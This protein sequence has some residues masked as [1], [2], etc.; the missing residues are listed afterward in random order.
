[1]FCLGSLQSFASGL[2]VVS[3]QMNIDAAPQASL[4]Y[5]RRH[6]LVFSFAAEDRTDVSLDEVSPAMVAAVL[7]AEDRSFFRH[8]GMNFIAIARAFYV[9]LRRQGIRQGGS[10]ITQQLVRQVALTPD[11]TFDRKV[12]EALLAFRL[13]RR[14]RKRQILAAYLNRIYLG[15]GHYGVE[16]AARGY[17]GKTAA[18]LN[19]AEAALLAGIIRCPGTC[20]P[21][22]APDAARMRRNTV[23]AAMRASGAV[24]AA[25]YKSA[26]A[27]P[28]VL[29]QEGDRR[30]PGSRGASGMYFI[31][32]VRRQVMSRFGQDDVLRGGLRIYTTLDMP[33]QVEA[34]RALTTR[35]DQIDPPHQTSSGLPERLQGALIALDPH[36]GEVLALVGGRDFN[37]SSFNRAVQAQRQPGSAFKALLFAAAI[38]QGYAPGSLVTDLETPIK[39]AQ[40]A[41]LPAGEHEAESYTLRQA[42]AVSSNRAAVRLMQMVGIGTTQN[43]AR[44]LGITSPLPAVPS[45]ALGTADVSLSDLTS[46]YSAFAND[47]IIAPQTLITR[48]EDRNGEVLWQPSDDRLPYRAV[49]PGTAYLMSSML[50]DVIDHG[51][52]TRARAEGF[53]LPA[54]GKTGTTDD[55]GDA[56][57]VGYTPTLVAGVWF[58]YDDHRPIMN[59]GFAAT[60]AVPAWAQFMMKATAGQP[61]SWFQPPAD[62]EQIQI[63]RITGLRASD[64]CEFNRADGTPNVY[65]DYFLAGTGPFERCPGHTAVEGQPEGETESKI[66]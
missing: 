25:E 14:F 65:A 1:M 22:I 54:A 66:E 39:T 47:G 43:Y 44:R 55:Y 37:E 41:W 24:S 46:A 2:N 5:D 16:A 17:F 18:E 26:A 50:A 57:F 62:V 52:G 48:I 30:Q 42:L 23:L 15:D 36:T 6:N 27:S 38:E 29:K 21:R 32:T 49:R 34:E 4:V 12:R 56:W 31:E 53:K 3:L 51:T 60:V 19:A 59:R 58:G 7:A 63:C 64:E 61:A 33:L 28:I 13:E 45:L 8:A 20:S 35:L 40:G 11:R 10:T 9:N